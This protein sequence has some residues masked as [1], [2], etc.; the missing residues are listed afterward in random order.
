MTSPA[1]PTGPVLE[2][3]DG[4]AE[5]LG[6][7][8]I[9]RLLPRRPRRT[10]GA[11]CFLD[12]MG[13][14]DALLQVGPHPHIGLQTVTW[15]LEGEVLHRDSLGV[16]QPIRPG[17]LNLMT[18][19]GG[20]AHAEEGRRGPLEGAQ[21][22]VALPD[23]TRHGPAAFEHHGDLP[24]AEVGNL[25]ATVLVGS[26]VGTDATSPARH[27]TPLLGAELRATGAGAARV[28]LEPA[29][30][31]ALAVLRGAV[32]IEDAETARAGQLVHLGTGRDGIGLSV[33]DDAVLLLLG[34]MPFD[35]H[36]VMWW[37]FVART[38]DEIDVARADW[39]EAQHGGFD[40]FGPVASALA[41]I[42]APPR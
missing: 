16:E 23:A 28:A 36:I 11:W 26:L 22:W 37:N 42:P 29:F 3:V 10:V 14:S 31:H 24:V 41:A 17:Q 25:A 7:V 40:R 5:E 30:E 15:L 35:E 6:G 20:V 18:A 8:P 1:S 2:L 12:Q 39:A 32:E 4:R 34:G 38:F 33:P 21:L 9:R 27:D 13:P 19:G